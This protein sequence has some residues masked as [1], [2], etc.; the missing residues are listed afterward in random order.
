MAAIQQ[1]RVS[2]NVRSEVYNNTT[3]INGDKAIA[4][5]VVQNIISD[6]GGNAQLRSLFNRISGPLTAEK[7]IMVLALLK[8]LPTLTV[9]P[10]EVNKNPQTGKTMITWKRYIDI[11][12]HQTTTF[13]TST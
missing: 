7:G 12:N 13:L 9:V 3:S 4:E 8:E 10:N 5:A 6:L 11:T 1:N 2:T